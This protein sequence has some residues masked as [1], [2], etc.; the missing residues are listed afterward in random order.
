MVGIDKKLD[1]GSTG[2]DQDVIRARIGVII[3]TSGCWLRFQQMADWA[4]ARE[5]PATVQ[6]RKVKL[7]K[8][9]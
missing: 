4:G 8:P 5:G 1:Q 3:T 2:T 7:G 6:A 9:I